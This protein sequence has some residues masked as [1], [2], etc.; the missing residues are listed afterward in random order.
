[1]VVAQKD[2]AV[3]GGEF[4]AGGADAGTELAG[5]AAG[6]PMTADGATPAAP[7]A[8]DRPGRPGQQRPGG[9]SLR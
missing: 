9:R 7:A 8:P 6:G 3:A 2:E 1:L 5:G 4:G